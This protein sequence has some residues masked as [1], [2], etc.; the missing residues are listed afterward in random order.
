ML[1]KEE[2]WDTVYNTDNVKRMFNSFYCILLRYLENSFPISYKSYGTDAMTGLCKV[3]KYHVSG[4][5]TFILYTETQ[6][7]SK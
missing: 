2:I 4:K 5:E 3:L 7:T 6:I 1:L